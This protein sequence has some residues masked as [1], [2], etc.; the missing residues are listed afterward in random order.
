MLR[1]TR[2][3]DPGGLSSLEVFACLVAALAHDVRHPGVNNAFLVA[4]KDELALRH[5]DKSPLENMHCAVLYELLS[6]TGLFAGLTAEQWRDVRKVIINVVLGTDMINHFDQVNKAKVR[7]LRTILLLQ[8]APLPPFFCHFPSLPLTFVWNSLR[9][10]LYPICRSSWRCTAQRLQ[11]SA[12]ANAQKIAV[13]LCVTICNAP[14][15]PSYY[16]IALTSVTP[17]GHLHYVRSGVF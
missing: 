2:L 11:P 8:H 7:A 6:R 17:A 14:S 3:G 12:V 4:S 5:N 1:L 9:F 15:W 10:R 13:N 16:C